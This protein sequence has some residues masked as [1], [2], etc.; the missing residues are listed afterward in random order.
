MAQNESRIAAGRSCRQATSANFGRRS[1]HPLTIERQTP[2]EPAVDSCPRRGMGA[3]NQK[4]SFSGRR[5]W[6]LREW[7]EPSLLCRA[8]RKPF[9]GAPKFA[10]KSGIEGDFRASF[11][12]SFDA[13]LSTVVW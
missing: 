9:G 4:T 13:G 10:Y 2:R 1:S 11:R 7:T 8:F 12:S 6:R 3:P 5:R